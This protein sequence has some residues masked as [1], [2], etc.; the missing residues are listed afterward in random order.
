M[1]IFSD[2]SYGMLLD[3]LVK[4]SVAFYGAQWLLCTTGT[5]HELDKSIP[6]S[7]NLLHPIK[8]NF[9]IVLPTTATKRY[10]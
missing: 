4:K 2:F 1:H 6:Y 9:N 3:K 7:H 10:P 8:I 5:H